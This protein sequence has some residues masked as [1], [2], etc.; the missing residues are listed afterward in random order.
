MKLLG[1]ESI[2]FEY[3]TVN[4][5]YR[6]AGTADRLYEATKAL[7]TP[8]GDVLPVG[9]L[10]VGDLKTGDKL[11]YSK[12]AYA[13]QL[14]LYAE[15]EMYDV[16]ADEFIA[17]PPINRDWAIIVHMPADEAGR[18]EFLWVDL[19]VGRHG[20][21]LVEQIK[22]WRKMW[23]SGEFSLP[24][25]E[26]N[27]APVEIAACFCGQPDDDAV[28]HQTVA[29]CYMK[30]AI[31]D[32]APAVDPPSELPP[33]GGGTLDDWL[34][35]VRERVTQIGTDPKARTALLFDWP[36]NVPTPKNMNSMAQVDRVLPI[37]NKIEADYSLGFVPR[38]A[39]LLS[40]GPAHNKKGK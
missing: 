4:I 20:A 26:L 33:D 24:P 1:L 39:A 37:L 31:V 7:V 2:R 22:L 29:P 28:V 10:L 23:R 6:C 38:P 30:S 35:W 19:A 8:D 21:Y 18:C 40:T 34:T 15:G 13:V 27:V 9:T 11:E 25:V 36:Q 5:Q 32:D 16:V 3:H 12:A 14:A 17:T